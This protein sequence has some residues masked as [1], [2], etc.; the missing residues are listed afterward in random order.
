MERKVGKGMGWSSGCG[1]AEGIWSDIKDVLP[2]ETKDK[3]A[4]KIYNA[5]CDMDADDWDFEEGNLYATALKVAYPE[6]YKEIMDT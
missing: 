6:D 4:V 3:V 5:F 2:I 1:L